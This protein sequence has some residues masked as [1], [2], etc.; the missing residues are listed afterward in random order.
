MN[1]KKFPVIPVIIIAA[2]LIGAAVLIAVSNQRRGEVRVLMTEMAAATETASVPTSTPTA[3]PT[4]VPTETPTEVLTEELPTEEPTAAPALD[5]ADWQNWPELPE[6][7]SPELKAMYFE[8]I[9]EGNDPARFSKVGDS[10]TVMPSFLGCFDSGEGTGYD[11]GPYEELQEVIE[12]FQWSFSRNSRAAKNGATAY[13]M[14]VYHWYTDDVCWPYESALSCEYRLFTPSIAFIGFGTNDALLD[15]DLYEE[16]LRSLV[17]KTLDRK[18]VPILLTKADDLEGDGSFNEVT[19]RIAAE[20]NVPLWNL[21]KAMSA[22][23]NNGL[24]DGD[25]HPTSSDVSLCNFAGS[26]L[27]NYGWTVRN[28]S[29][30]KAL[31]RVW[32]LLNDLPLNEY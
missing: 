2:L 8:G 24:K 32:R 17:Q 16:H 26:D 31:D 20:F 28:L 27:E 4:S 15:I 30:L 21:W 14:D 13:D 5:P 22:L 1:K 11:L 29:A 23:P 7:I 18:I 9:E 6:S 12:Q 3:E 25:V 19:A 10:N